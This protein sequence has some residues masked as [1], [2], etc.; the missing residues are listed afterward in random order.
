MM[1]GCQ[2]TTI[3]FPLENG[4]AMR[5]RIND[6]GPF[7]RGRII[8]LSRRSAQLLGFEKA[9]TALV[10]ITIIA[11]ESRRFAINADKKKIRA[12]LQPRE[13]ISFR[14]LNGRNNQSKANLGKGF[15]TKKRLE[16]KQ[17]KVKKFV[18]KSKKVRKNLSIFVQAG[19]FLHKE[20][21]EKM[22]KLLD[23]VGQTRVIETII[24]NRQFYRV[25]VGPVNSVKA[26]DEL[27]GLVV[28]S[29][30]PNAQ[31]VVQ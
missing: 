10:Q 27:L 28:A 13:K 25:Q 30:Y 18:N 21:A 26:G 22:K 2:N 1:P 23:P 7:I 15:P 12:K 19:S 11:N 24:G 31:F 8:D 17:R 29:G 20:L 16:T 4:R 9:G 14:P 6:R 3:P 5:L